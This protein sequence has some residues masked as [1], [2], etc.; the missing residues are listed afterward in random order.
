MGTGETPVQFSFLG[1][2]PY[3]HYLFLF[4]C[5]CKIP[6]CVGGTIQYQHFTNGKCMRPKRLK[7]KSYNHSEVFE[8]NIHDNVIKRT[9]GFNDADRFVTLILD[10]MKI[11]K[12]RHCHKYLE[13]WKEIATHA[14]A[15]FARG[16][17][18]DLKYS[19]GAYLEDSRASMMELFCENI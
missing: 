12:N 13:L 10:E 19:S 9:S 15:Y 18:S 14:L 7:K 16:C 8:K 17:F 3:C 5:S 4:I 11:K 1:S 2:L 6:F